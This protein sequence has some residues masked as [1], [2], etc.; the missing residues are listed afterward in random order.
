MPILLLAC[1]HAAIVHTLLACTTMYAELLIP[2]H[3]GSTTTEMLASLA[4]CKI[5]VVT[6]NQYMYIFL[7]AVRIPITLIALGW[8]FWAAVPFVGGSV[9]QRYQYSLHNITQY[10]SM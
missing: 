2:I 6:I 9:Q 5:C 4:G 10:I 3:A 7:Q 1:Y 8:S